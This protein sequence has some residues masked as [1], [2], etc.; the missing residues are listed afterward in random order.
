VVWIGIGHE[1][2]GLRKIMRSKLKIRIYGNYEVVNDPL[3]MR[4]ILEC[5][6]LKDTNDGKLLLR[7]HI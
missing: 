2:Y 4:I 6:R 1:I 7:K 3:E 5:R